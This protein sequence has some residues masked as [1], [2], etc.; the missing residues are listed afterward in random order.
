MRFNNLAKSVYFE[1]KH[2]Y[3][4]VDGSTTFTPKEGFVIEV[5]ELE[6]YGPV[7]FIE[8]ASISDKIISI[9]FESGHDVRVGL[10]SNIRFRV[11]KLEVLGYV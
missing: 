4:Q 6:S 2:G 5:E 10:T 9:V 11:S 3:V 7:E 8:H 1:K